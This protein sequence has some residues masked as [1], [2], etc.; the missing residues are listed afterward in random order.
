MRPLLD[1]LSALHDAGVRLVVV[2]GVAVVL[3]GHPR[4]TADLD[5]V[6]DLSTENALAAVRVLQGAGLVPR[7]PVEAERFADREVREQ[8]TQE[9]Q[10]TVFSLHD[11]TDPRREVD[12]FAESPVPFEELW[13]QSKLIT[14]NDVPV[15]VAGIP[16]LITMKRRAGRPQ[17][18]ADIAALEALLR[19]TGTDD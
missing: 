2:G 10:L 8:W 12:L 19:E 7:L 11:P 3:H 16:H 5:L 15:R 1:L 4:L 14:V 18:L 9:R 13:D 17:D 6:I